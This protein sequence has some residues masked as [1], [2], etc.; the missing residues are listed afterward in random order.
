M[1]TK[2]YIGSDESYD[3]FRNGFLILAFVVI[4]NEKDHLYFQSEFSK[5]QTKLGLAEFKNNK[6]HPNDRQKFFNLLSKM[7]LEIYIYKSQMNSTKDVEATY[8]NGLKSFAEALS[9]R[10]HLH[11]L[12]MRLDEIGGAKFQ[13]ECTS[14]IHSSLKN[15]HIKKDIKFVSSKNNLLVQVSDIIGG[16]SRKMLHGKSQFA[17]YLSKNKNLF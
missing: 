3:A 11:Q 1:D 12:D 13:N 8:R 14:L 6:L 7:N 15:R 5:L 9:K 4:N 10:K 16:E 2:L 17:K